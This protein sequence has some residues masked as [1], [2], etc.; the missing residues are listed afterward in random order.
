MC[1]KDAP[2]DDVLTSSRLIFIQ[3]MQLLTS[4][5][6]RL[7]GPAELVVKQGEGMISRGGEGWDCTRK[8]LRTSYCHC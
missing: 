6:V 7:F 2:L 3:A 5:P 8:D 1:L 4:V